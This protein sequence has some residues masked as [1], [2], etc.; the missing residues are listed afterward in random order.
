MKPGPDLQSAR[1]TSVE[2]TSPLVRRRCSCGCST[3]GMLH[4]PGGRSR[5]VVH[6]AGLGAGEEAAA[7]SRRF[8]SPDFAVFSP[9]LDFRDR[10]ALYLPHA[11]V[12]ESR[13]R[14]AASVGVDSKALVT[15][16]TPELL[17]RV[18]HNS[19]RAARLPL[20]AE[21]YVA[22]PRVL[23]GG[24]RQS[25]AAGRL[26]ARSRWTFSGLSRTARR[27]CWT[28]RPSWGHD[29]RWSHR[30]TE[31]RCLPDPP[32]ELRARL[33]KVIAGCLPRRSALRDYGRVDLRLTGNTNEFLR[34]S[35]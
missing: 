3:P 5:G 17:E 29:Q 35:R 19:P 23:R 8:A 7:R 18:L 27:M 1:G 25:G 24:D 16:A 9:D 28:P 33:Q 10:R 12:R 34:C 31:S 14:A 6:P 11:A 13:W 2:G 32:D 22:G 20:L 26:P 15:E 4:D 30:G 21:E